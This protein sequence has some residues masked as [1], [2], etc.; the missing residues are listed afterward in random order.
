LLSTSFF[1]ICLS[2]NKGKHIRVN[3]GIIFVKASHAYEFVSNRYI[4]YDPLI[5][6]HLNNGTELKC[7]VQEDLVY[8]A[9]G[10]IFINWEVVNISLPTLTY[11]KYDV[12]HPSVLTRKIL[13]A[14]SGILL[15][16]STRNMWN[17]KTSN[18]MN[19]INMRKIFFHR[20]FMTNVHWKRNKKKRFINT[21]RNK[22]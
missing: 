10:T 16:T 12:I 22:I 8:S 6:A 21:I 5:K 11:C 14:D 18:T 9:N 4:P 19:I 1:Y 2:W 3:C 17:L 15:F 20:W 13:L 7:V